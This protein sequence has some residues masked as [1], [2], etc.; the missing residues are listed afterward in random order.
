MIY[1]IEE[2][3]IVYNYDQGLYCGLD[4]CYTKI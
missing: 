3:I 4:R 1:Y 2:I